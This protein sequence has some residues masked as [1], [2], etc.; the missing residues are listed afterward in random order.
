MRSNEFSVLRNLKNVTTNYI[1]LP[2]YQNITTI[3]WKNVGK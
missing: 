1:Y 3:L 2:V